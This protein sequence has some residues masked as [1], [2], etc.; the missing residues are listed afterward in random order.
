MS[1]SQRG[2]SSG[3]FP[4]WDPTMA[5]SRAL[6]LSLALRASFAHLMGRT[7]V[8]L[9][10]QP[11]VA[12]ERHRRCQDFATVRR[13]LD[14]VPAGLCPGQVRVHL[15][16]TEVVRLCFDAVDADDVDRSR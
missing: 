8:L 4:T 1:L 11:L 2:E 9:E 7:I 13:Q 5:S 14:G 16:L 15:K 3:G 12:Q 10:L 6:T